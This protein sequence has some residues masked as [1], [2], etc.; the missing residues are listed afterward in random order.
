MAKQL[1]RGP[2]VSEPKRIRT[3][4]TYKADSVLLQPVKVAEL[5]TEGE[6]TIYLLAE[7]TFTKGAATFSAVTLCIVEKLTV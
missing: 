6:K 5:V 7:E 2:S 4:V 3:R 1:R